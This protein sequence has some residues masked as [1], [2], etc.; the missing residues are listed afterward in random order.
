MDGCRAAQTER[1][2]NTNLQSN[3]ELKYTESTIRILPAEQHRQKEACANERALQV[4]SV[5]LG[6]GGLIGTKLIK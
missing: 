4:A 6:S 3:I 5:P 1:E 2:K